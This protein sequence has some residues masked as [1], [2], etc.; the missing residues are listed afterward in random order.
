[1]VANLAVDLQPG[2]YVAEWVSP[3][4]GKVEKREEF[5]HLAGVRTIVSPEYSE[6]MALRIK[7]VKSP[8][9]TP[10]KAQPKN[11]D[12]PIVQPRPKK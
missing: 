10:V 11:P 2:A 3:K 8:V 12:K 1:M 5:D 7:R 6:D 4:T 9:K